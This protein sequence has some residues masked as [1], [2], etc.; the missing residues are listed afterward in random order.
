M[1]RAKHRTRFVFRERRASRKTE[2]CD[3]K[4]PEDPAFQMFRV[5]YFYRLLLFSTRTCRAPRSVQR[6][7]KTRNWK[8]LKLGHCRGGYEL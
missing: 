4:I 8:R 7:I 6:R 2:K 5:T 1:V 3:R